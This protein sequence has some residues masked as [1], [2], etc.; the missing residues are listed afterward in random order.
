MKYV[1]IQD[2]TY[3]IPEQEAEAIDHMIAADIDKAPIYAVP[4]DSVEEAEAAGWVDQVRTAGELFQSQSNRGVRQA[5]GLF[6]E[7]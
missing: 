1:V 6:L 2:T 5:D 7:R 4:Q 3:Q